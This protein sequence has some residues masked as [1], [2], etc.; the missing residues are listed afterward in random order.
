MTSYRRGM[1]KREYLKGGRE[2]RI[3]KCS[4]ANLTVVMGMKN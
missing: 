1:S 3:M 2:E 4:L